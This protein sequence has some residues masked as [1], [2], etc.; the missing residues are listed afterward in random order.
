MSS[1]QTT[2]M[3]N[4]RWVICSMLFFATT[5]NYMDRQVLSLTWKDFIAPEFHWT[6]DDYGTITAVFSILYAVFCL[7]AGKF[8]D[9]MGTKKGYLWSIFVWSLGACLHAVCGWIT[10][11][12]EGLD[13]VEA[14]R[15]V[16]AGSAT[17]LS[18]ATISV[19]L[20][21]F[22][23]SVLAMG[24]SGNFPAAIKVTAEYFPKKDRAFSTSIFNAGASVGALVAPLSIP[25]LAEWFGWE[26][27]FIIIGVLGFVWMGFW[28]VFYEKPNKSNHVNVAELTYINQDAETDADP[29]DADDEG[30]QISFLNCFTYRQTWSFIVGKFMTDGVW[31]FFLFWAPAYFSDQFG[32]KSSSG[33]G[34]LLIFTLYFIVTVLSIFGGYLPKYFVEK[35][36]MGAYAGRM[37]A[38]LLFTF[39]PMTALLAQPLAAWEASPIDPAWWPA[40]IIGL[41]GAGHQAWSANLFSTIGDMFP[42]STI[43]T[44][45]GIGAMAGGLGSM[46]INKCSGKLFTYAEQQG[47]DFTFF[48]FEGKPAGYM[49]VFCICAIAYIIGWT[50]MKV[51][52]PKYKPIVVE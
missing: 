31:W 29:K 22:C 51:L 14:L 49:I 30:P 41:A 34:Q 38:M 18:I 13:S 5:I 36:G 50:I 21:L 39:F 25:P 4:Y 12:Y 33:M 32:Y 37:R 45:T 40:I 1:V 43:A 26:M 48:G 7:F 24:E 46:L 19:Y 35:K 9:W 17:A 15:A 10:M 23:R 11:K 28:V 52:V 2:K 8:I 27:A 42:K 47:A 44:I 3:T 6:D 16:Q 20:F